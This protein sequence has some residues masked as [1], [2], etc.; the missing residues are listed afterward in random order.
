MSVHEDVYV[1]LCVHIYMY[2]IYVK[3]QNVN[4]NY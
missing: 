4:Q 1:C 3:F 2:K